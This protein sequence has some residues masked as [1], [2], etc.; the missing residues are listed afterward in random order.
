MHTLVKAVFAD[1]LRLA[2][3]TALP[4]LGVLALAST[5]AAQAPGN[6]P[7]GPP[8]GAPGAA[9][10]NPNP[11]GPPPSFN[12]GGNPGAPPGGFNPGAPPGNWP[13]DPN[14]AP[15]V[16]GQPPAQF[17]NEPPPV[18]APDVPGDETEERYLALGEHSNFIGSIGLLHTSYAGSGAPGSFRVS[19]ISDFFSV[20]NF[21]CRPK[22]VAYGASA[23]GQAVFKGCGGSNTSDH[24]G[25]VGG[26]F[27]L[28]ATPLSFLEAYITLRTYANSDDHG[29][30]QLLQV[31][32][33]TTLGVKAF[34]PTHLGKVFTFGGEAQL[35]LLNGTGGVGLAGGGTSANFRGLASADLRKP[36]AAGGGAPLRFNLNLGYKL[37]NS[38]VLVRDVE[39]KRAAAKGL[40]NDPAVDDTKARDPI[41]RI[42][43]FGLGINRVDTFQIA[44]GAEAPFSRV[45]P[46]L[47]WSVDVPVNRQGYKCHT[48]RAY[49]GDECLGLNN[50]NLPAD[51]AKTAG[52]P[53]F[54]AVPSRFTLGLRTNPFPDRFH[55]LSAHIAMD[56]GTSGVS[57]FVEEVAPQAPWTMY[58]GIA[59]AYDLKEKEVVVAP[60]PPPQ[61]IPAPQTF[62]R[63]FV[64]EAGK[65][66]V[67]A[68]DAL[69]HFEGNVQAPIAT[70]PDGKF[71]TRNLEAGTYKF[72]IK[73]AG[74]KP[75]TCSATVVPAAPPGGGMG[76]DPNAPP[77]MGGNPAFG[78]PG[79]A[80]SPFGPAPMN[81]PGA[82]GA[83]GAP[84]GAPGN[85]AFGG[86]PAPIAPAQPQGPIYVDI[87]C[88]LE[89]LPRV[90]GILGTV[91]DAEKGGPL[92][93]A[94][95][96]V[97][98]S[99]GKA[100]SA[101]ADGGGNFVL[102][103][104]KPGAYTIRASANDYLGK[105]AAVEV[106][107][108][109]DAR[110][111][112]SLIKRPKISSAKIQGNEI[113]VSKQIHFETDSA[114]IQGDS[115]QLMEEIAD[116]LHR[117]PGIRKVEIQGHTDNTGTREHNLQLSDARANSV[118]AWLVGAGIDPN[119]LTAKGYGQER[120]LAPN[121]TAMN[122][123]R[124]RRVQFIILEGK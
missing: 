53:G 36:E 116:V 35:L 69:V 102:K 80:P 31:L 26:L 94:S 81:N 109:E 61:I 16:D 88:P 48:S 119:R 27:T 114:K 34:T 66:D 124:N 23:Q 3:R 42:E 110:P 101:T 55:G 92:G 20:G 41:T 54:K 86:P 84:P 68:V 72:N 1:S 97:I 60:A 51:Q 33:D 44:V 57:T 120:P 75:G 32:G 113:R 59:Y 63:G 115:N 56:I 52:G 19:F 65:T 118:K 17:G 123:T 46:Y 10:G 90:G 103:D 49:E 24:A 15:P 107:A 105:V 13:S 14:A 37:D 108:S 71:L 43:R 87:D 7:F 93:G 100:V 73:A 98:D 2:S 8:P 96:T 39:E 25:H 122:R 82:P 5:A 28:N 21:L 6:N 89:A 22:D 45:Q 38:G 47:E 64:H 12:P 117:N 78:N 106:R 50:F 77:G 121:V 9:P 83:P 79:G 111:S 40:V 62:V 58:L 99:T 91:R 95:I 70:G 112:L 74:F 67:I 11:F 104:L 29:S 18:A 30:P 4:L 76:M 85:P